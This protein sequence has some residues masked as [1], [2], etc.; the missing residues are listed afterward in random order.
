MWC[1]LFW[2]RGS[3]KYVRLLAGVEHVLLLMYKHRASRDR[4]L[5]VKCCVATDKHVIVAPFSLL[6]G[7]FKLSCV[8]FVK[9][10]QFLK[11]EA[12]PA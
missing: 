2:Q 3:W 1:G 11:G 12:T 5:V 4:A 9:L 7:C 10:I 8:V 6:Q